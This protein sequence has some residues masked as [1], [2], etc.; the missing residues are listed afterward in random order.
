MNGCT[1]DPDP[2]QRFIYVG[3]VGGCQAPMGVNKNPSSYR[4]FTFIPSFLT[5]F[6]PQQLIQ[7]TVWDE[8]SFAGIVFEMAH[9]DWGLDSRG[10]GCGKEQFFT[11]FPGLYCR[12]LGLQLTFSTCFHVFKGQGQ[13]LVFSLNSWGK[14]PHFLLNDFQKW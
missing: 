6:I 7:Q 13:F 9:I 4:C 10:L 11:L 14:F 3:R 2:R 5:S 12:Q 1:G 8:I